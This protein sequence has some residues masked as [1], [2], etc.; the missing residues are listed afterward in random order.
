MEVWNLCSLLLIKEYSKQNDTV[1]RGRERE[2]SKH[3][4]S[5]AGTD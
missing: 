2:K 1:K 5:P 3:K 4:K